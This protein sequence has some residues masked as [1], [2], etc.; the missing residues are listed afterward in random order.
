MAGLTGIKPE[1]DVHLA[2]VLTGGCDLWLKTPQPPLEASGTSSMKAAVNGVPSLSILDG[3]W[4]EGC[5]EGVGWAI[6]RD[7]SVA[8]DDEGKADTL[9]CTTTSRPIP[10]SVR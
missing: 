3:W 6:G 8:I 7:N 10:F 4:V 2:R 5:I 9:R 1:Y